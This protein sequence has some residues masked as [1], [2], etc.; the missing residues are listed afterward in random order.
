MVEIHKLFGVH[1]N[2]KSSN[3]M[4]DS[5]W[6]V[7]VSDFGYQNLLERTSKED[8]DDYADLKGRMV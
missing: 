5:R 2:L 7:K 6:V 3:C 1:G 4:I 8:N